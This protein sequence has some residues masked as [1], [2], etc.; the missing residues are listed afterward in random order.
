MSV[1]RPPFEPEDFPVNS[2][3]SQWFVQY[4][5]PY[6]NRIQ[7]AIRAAI[8]RQYI[9]DAGDERWGIPWG[10]DKDVAAPLMKLVATLPANVKVICPPGQHVLKVPLELV[11]LP[12]VGLYAAHSPFPDGAG[13]ATTFVSGKSQS[14]GTMLSILSCDHPELF[15]FAFQTDRGTRE[16]CALTID[17]NALSGPN[18]TVISTAARIRFCLFRAQNPNPDLTLVRLSDATD[19]NNE[20][21]EFDHC[22][23]SGGPAVPN[24]VGRGVTLAEASESANAK[25][26]AFRRCYFNYL[27]TGYLQG[28]GSCQFTEASFTGNGTDL[29][30]D[31]ASESC[32][33]AKS[34][35]EHSQCHVRLNSGRAMRFT[36]PRVGMT[37]TPAG[38]SCFRFA[39]AD[40]VTLEDVQ[41][42]QV[43][44]TGTTFF[45]ATGA[46]LKLDIDGIEFPAATTMA[47]LGIPT[48]ENYY[49][50]VRGARN[51]IDLPA[52]DTLFAGSLMQGKTAMAIVA[53]PSA[54][55]DAVMSAVR[56]PQIL[57][58][59]PAAIDAQLAPGTF[60]PFELNGQLVLRHRNAVGAL[61]TYSLPRL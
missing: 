27:G 53:L 23:F 3:I 4:A 37:K 49:A 60:M 15:G 42:D 33:F 52:E 44:P 47:Q 57:G 2:R 36:A 45:D 9:L 12:G 56:G 7:D 19:Q 30:I 29:E 46:H 22:V 21:G 43:P 6:L 51:V 17:E 8:P 40:H 48:V 35:M 28:N 32:T 41:C 54:E 38:G 55:R 14:G 50:R 31:G 10:T 11:A 20:Y 1:L 26:W 59:A 18:G 13:L 61:A 25:M 16:N 58:A 34:N 39:H 24:P 5:V